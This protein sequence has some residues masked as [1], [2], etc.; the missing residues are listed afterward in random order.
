MEKLPQ[1]LAPPFGTQSVIRCG[2]GGDGGDGGAGGGDGGDGSSG[3]DGGDDG[4]LSTSSSPPP[5][6]WP[7]VWPP[8]LTSTTAAAMQGDLV[9][10]RAH[11]HGSEALGEGGRA[12]ARRTDREEGGLEHHHS[13]QCRRLIW[14]PTP[15]L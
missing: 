12:G 6:P 4:G 10:S 1:E 8:A 5:W 13:F 15:S 3:G 2:G 7:P 9:V 14:V 11:A